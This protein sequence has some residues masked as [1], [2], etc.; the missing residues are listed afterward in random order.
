MY[1]AV[2]RKT[3]TRYNGTHFEIC[4]TERLVSFVVLV[5]VVI[6]VVVFEMLKVLFVVWCLL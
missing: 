1:V 4:G 3:Y 2:D 6:E 5:V